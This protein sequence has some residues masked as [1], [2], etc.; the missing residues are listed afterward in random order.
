MLFTTAGHQD[1]PEYSVHERFDVPMLY[2]TDAPATGEGYDLAV[3]LGH[4]LL[5]HP[6]ARHTAAQAQAVVLVIDPSVVSREMAQRAIGLLREVKAP[7]VGVVV[8]RVRSGRLRRAYEQ[9]AEVRKV[10]RGTAGKS[11]RDKV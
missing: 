4:A 8:N 7:L 9:R 2:C 11:E 6:E 10:A 3:R 1:A 5:A